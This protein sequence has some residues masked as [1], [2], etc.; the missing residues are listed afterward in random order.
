MVLIHF[1]LLWPKAK[2]ISRLSL[3]VRDG[4]KGSRMFKLVYVYNVHR[5]RSEFFKWEMNM[6]SNIL[7]WFL[8]ALLVAAIVPKYFS[9]QFSRGDDFGFILS[10][11]SPNAPLNGNMHSA[12]VNKDSAWSLKRTPQE[13]ICYIVVL[14]C[15]WCFSSF[16]L[17]YCGNKRRAPE[18]HEG[19]QMTRGWVQWMVFHSPVSSHGKPYIQEINGFGKRLPRLNTSSVKLLQPSGV[20]HNVWYCILY[21]KMI[22]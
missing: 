21:L 6:I 18:R 22:I 17:E 14:Y 11:D 2:V 5:S 7:P 3:W 16:S 12:R 4:P 1:T 8:S 13:R 10:N 19:T 15:C 20:A 9:Y